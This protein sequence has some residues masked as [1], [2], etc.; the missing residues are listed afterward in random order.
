[1][2]TL[3]ASRGE[4]PIF[5][6]YFQLYYQD[7]LSI[8]T[9]ITRDSYLAEDVV[10]ESFIKAYYHQ[11]N[12]EDK[13]KWKAWLKTIVKRTAIDVLRKQQRMQTIPADDW[14]QNHII[15]E[16]RCCSY[17]EEAMEKNIK[18][19]QITN[20][21]ES[22]NPSLR[23]VLYL[24][25][26]FDLTDKEIAQKLLISISAVKTRLYRARIKL[27]KLLKDEFNTTFQQWLEVS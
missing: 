9:H 7:M 13:S 23:D 10:Q 14:L 17:V 22:L 15:I 6:C 5:Y 24:K 26:H 19:Q 3:E 20:A 1:M 2:L 27:Q 16:N 4:N 11:H 12:I 18:Y 8:A 21:I 25:L